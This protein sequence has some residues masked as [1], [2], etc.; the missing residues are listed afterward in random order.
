MLL[1]KITYEYS[2][3]TYSTRYDMYFIFYTKITSSYIPRFSYD[4][5]EKMTNMYPYILHMCMYYLNPSLASSR[6]VCTWARV[7]LTKKKEFKPLPPSHPLRVIDKVKLNAAQIQ[8]IRGGIRR[9]PAFFKGHVT[10]HVLYEMRWNVG[11][12][13]TC[14]VPVVKY[15]TPRFFVFIGVAYV[16]CTCTSASTRSHI[17]LSITLHRMTGGPIIEVVMRK[18]G[19]CHPW[20][21]VVS[22]NRCGVY[23]SVRGRW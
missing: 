9:H 20:W 21:W 17:M 1:S 15:E 22:K 3:C 5:Q 2:V 12:I 10:I 7:Q 23:F 16:S 8:T 4:R 18:V 14:N 6:G 13:V 19:L 11:W